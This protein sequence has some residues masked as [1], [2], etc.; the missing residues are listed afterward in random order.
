MNLRGVLNFV[1]LAVR[2]MRKVGGG[3]EGGRGGSI[4]ITW[5]ATVYAPEQSLPVYSASKL[6]VCFPP[7]FKP[8]FSAYLRVCVCVC[9]VIYHNSSS[10]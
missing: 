4:V 7:P 8:P 5:S 3:D 2:A 1:K 6:A 10:V 9:G